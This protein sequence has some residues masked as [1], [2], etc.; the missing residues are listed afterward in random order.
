LEIVVSNDVPE[1]ED[2]EKNEVDE[3]D[4]L[5]GIQEDG[6]EMNPYQDQDVSTEVEIVVS[7]DVPENEDN[8]KNETNVMLFLLMMGIV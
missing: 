2:N 3:P 6:L 7:N 1:N 4:S 5:P 8:E